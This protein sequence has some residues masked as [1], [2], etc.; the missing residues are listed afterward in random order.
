MIRIGKLRIDAVR[1]MKG[2]VFLLLG[3]GIFLLH[4][5]KWMPFNL[6]VTEGLFLA[7]IWS[8]GGFF[9]GPIL[10]TYGI[11]Q[12]LTTEYSWG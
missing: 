1:I 10:A 6:D 9:L 7:Y 2:I 12:F 11:W 4:Q 3:I 8:Y 5:A